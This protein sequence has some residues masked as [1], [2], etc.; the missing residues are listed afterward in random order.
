MASGSAG[1]PY[2]LYRPPQAYGAPA[3]SDS[4]DGAAPPSPQNNSSQPTTKRNKRKNFKPRCA[5]AAYP[6]EQSEVAAMDLADYADNNNLKGVRRRKTLATRKLVVDARLSP[7]DLSKNN[8]SESG[9]DSS[10]NG[11]TVSDENL[12]FFLILWK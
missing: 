7:M 12:I 6:A 2:D 11:N 9:S 10:E 3:D 4:E 1:G 8:G 5:N